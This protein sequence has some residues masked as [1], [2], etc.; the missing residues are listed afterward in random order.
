VTPENLLLDSISSGALNED[1]PRV[2][3]G[4]RNELEF[5]AKKEALLAHEFENLSASL[6][7]KNDAESDGLSLSTILI[8]NDQLLAPSLSLCVMKY[9]N[10]IV[11]Y[12][13]SSETQQSAESDFLRAFLKFTVRSSSVTERGVSF[14]VWPAFNGN[15][16]LQTQHVSFLNVFGRFLDSIDWSPL[17]YL[18]Y[19]GYHFHHIEQQLLDTKIAKDSE[20]IFVPLQLAIPELLGSPVKKRSLWESVSK[21][22][23]L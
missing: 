1:V 10:V 17:N 8:G 16:L 12:E 7:A 2:L 9:E 23:V 22:T 21:L 15:L 18:F 20:C 4:V 5:V 11:F 19:F 6:S 14:F 13:V 3:S